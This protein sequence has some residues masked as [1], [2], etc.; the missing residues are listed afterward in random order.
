MRLFLLCRSKW[1]DQLS[2][3]ID[4]FFY[5]R[6]TGLK[7]GLKACS[8]VKDDLGWFW[9]RWKKYVD[10]SKLLIRI[11]ERHQLLIFSCFILDSEVVLLLQKGLHWSCYIRGFYDIFWGIVKGY[12]N[13]LELDHLLLLLLDQIS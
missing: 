9:R 11:S 5:D 3:S 12:E 8:R 4:W 7:N 1:I 13:I 2:R 6:N 10:S